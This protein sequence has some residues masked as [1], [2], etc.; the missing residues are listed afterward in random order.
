MQILPLFLCIFTF[1]YASTLIDQRKSRNLQKRYIYIPLC[2][3]FNTPA[4]PRRRCRSWIYIP[5][6]FYFN[7]GR[8]RSDR[9]RSGIYIPLCFYFNK[10]GSGYCIELVKFTFH[11][12]STL[13][14]K[15]KSQTGNGKLIYIPLCFYFNATLCSRKFPVLLIY[16]PLCFY[17]N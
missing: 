9:H 8:H 16:I 11:Y 5:L 7:S 10:G 6:C 1:H 14:E 17:F 4:S 15:P 2:F 12:A 13:I 3:Y